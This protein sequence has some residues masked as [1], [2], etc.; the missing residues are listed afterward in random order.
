MPLWSGVYMHTLEK[1]LKEVQLKNT[2]SKNPTQ[3]SK[4]CFIYIKNLA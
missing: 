3:S 4:K 1:I 2:K